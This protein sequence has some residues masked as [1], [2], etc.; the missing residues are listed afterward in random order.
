MRMRTTWL[1]IT[2]AYQAHSAPCGTERHITATIIPPIP[3]E[4]LVDA[5]RESGVSWRERIHTVTDQRGESYAI[6]TTCRAL[7]TH[8]TGEHVSKQR[9]AT[10]VAARHPEWSELIAMALER[11][12]SEDDNGPVDTLPET[13]RF[14]EW[15]TA[16]LETDP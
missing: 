11:R 4:V 9:A 13:I 14:I 16:E 10:W 1:A 6:L 7:Y 2:S 8:H 15:A 12:V 3:R 5:A